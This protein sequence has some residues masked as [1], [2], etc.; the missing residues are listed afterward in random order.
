M[1]CLSLCFPQSITVFFPFIMLIIFGFLAL[2]V[3]KIIQTGDISQLRNIKLIKHS[4]VLRKA[5]LPGKSPSING[6]KAPFLSEDDEIFTN[7]VTRHYYCPP[8]TIDELR[9][10]YG[11]SQSIWGE[12][13]CAETRR[14]YRQ[15]LP[16]ALQMDGVMGLSLE[17]RARIAAEARHAL[18]VYARE[19]CN[20]WGRVAAV[21]YDG[22]RHFHTFGYWSNTGMSW[23]EVKDK[24]T[25][26]AIVELGPEATDEDLLERV[27]ELIV[28]RAC[29][30]NEMLDRVANKD[31]SIM[32][33]L[34]DVIDEF[35]R[36]GP[37]TEASGSIANSI[38]IP[39]NKPS[40][41]N[42]NDIKRKK[43]GS[44]S[45]M[46]RRVKSSVTVLLRSL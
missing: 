39:T 44:L 46:G 34:F 16:V 18:R 41:A 36:K 25:R 17:E 26:R 13:T 8:T 6:N 30:T 31:N 7:P 2:G 45:Y 38:R 33:I 24:Y 9:R 35:R 4:N 20:L 3:S 32:E 15:Q 1:T 11:R 10:R 5:L 14:F 43:R 22:V 23:Q 12:W 27:Y 42:S 37:R 19:R 40:K 28:N 29:S 21:V